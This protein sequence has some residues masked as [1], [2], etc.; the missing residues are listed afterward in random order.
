MT[1]P[2]QGE[3]R[4]HDQPAVEAVHQGLLLGRTVGQGIGP[5]GE[6]Q[7]GAEGQAK[8]PADLVKGGHHAG[9]GAGFPVLHV[10]DRRYLGRNADG[11]DAHAEKD[12]PSR[13]AAHLL[14]VDGGKEEHSQKSGSVERE[15]GAGRAQ[16]AALQQ[17]ERYQRGRGPPLDQAASSTTPASRKPITSGEL[18]PTGWARTTP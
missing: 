16:R 17:P 14:K 2:Q 9:G 6:R 15:C 10:D 18:Q 5:A 12:Q 1:T 3:H 8:C 13:L 4:G 11:D 7:R